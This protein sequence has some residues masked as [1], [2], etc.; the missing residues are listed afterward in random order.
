MTQLIAPHDL[1]CT[2]VRRRTTPDGGLL[3]VF[4]DAEQRIVLCV[5]IGEGTTDVDE[6]FLR[7]LVAIVADVG[8]A[9]IVFAVVRPTGR[10]LRI[11]KLL[12]RQLR[13]R[14]D[15]SP[16]RLLDVMVVGEQLCWSAATGRLRDV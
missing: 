6:L 5:E 2:E 9:A 10:P 4:L 1:I 12:W 11:D 15:G 16:T 13:D 3:G 14:L 7:H 8:L